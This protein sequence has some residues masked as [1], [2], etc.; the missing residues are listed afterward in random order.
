MAT[1]IYKKDD[2]GNVIAETCEAGMLQGR[3]AQGYVVDPAEFEKVEIDG[4]KSQYDGCSNDEIREFAKRAGIDGYETIRIKKL[5][6]LLDAK[7]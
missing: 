6:A 3:L 1:R 7:G 2:G 4:T 5:K